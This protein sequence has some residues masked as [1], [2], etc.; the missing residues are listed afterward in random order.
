MGTGYWISRPTRAVALIAAGAIGAGAAVAVASVPDSSGVIHACVTTDGN[1]V[2]IT[3][4]SNVRII[5]PGAGQTCN[6]AVGAAPAA[7]SVTWNSAGQQGPVGPQGPAGPTGPAGADG[8]TIT[9]NGETFTI[10]GLKR[11]GTVGNVLPTAPA[12]PSGRSVGELALGSGR[13]ATTFD[14]LGWSVAAASGTSSTAAGKKT[15]SELQIT[16]LVDKSSASLFKLCVT[17]KHIK[18]VTL[19][20]RKAG[21]V[22]QLTVKLTN[23]V[24]SAYAE[25]SSSS[26]PTETLSLNFT[27]IQY[28]Y[29]Q[30]K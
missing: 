29:P 9:L 23:V 3:S 28:A 1:G 27:K 5:D 20:V 7:E 17:G 12:N 24:I 8:H 16:K 22:S 25:T 6:S 2:P 13:G 18:L 21:G 26:K 15:T 19:T 14:V 4:G 11:T 10:S 30:Q